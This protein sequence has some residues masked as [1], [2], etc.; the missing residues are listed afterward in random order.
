MSYRLGVDLG[1]TFSAAAIE[2]DGRAEIVALGNN[3]AQIPSVLFLQPDGN[4]RFGEAANRRGAE[5]PTRLAREFKRRIGDRTSIMVGSTPISPQALTAKLLR[6]TFDRVVERQGG[7]PALTVVT[8]PANWGEY[9]REL[10]SNATHEADIGAAELCPEPEA[11]AVHFSSTDRVRTGE[12][13]AVYDLGGGTFD[14]A[15]LRRTAEGFQLLG[16][17]EG[18]E[19]LGG[20]DFDEAVF[21]H[22]LTS[23]DGDIRGLDSDDPD[24]LSALARLRRE[25]VEAKE[26]LSADNEAPIP[27]TLPG[28]QRTVRLTRSEFEDMIRPRLTETVDC[29]ARAL[30]SA[31]LAPTDLAAVVLV[32]GS[33]R[34]P[35]VSEMLTQQFRRPIALSPHPKHCVALGAALRAVPRPSPGAEARAS[36][37]VPAGP[38]PVSAGPIKAVPVSGEPVKAVPVSAVPVSTAPASPAPATTS[39]DAARSRPARSR[40][41]RSSR[42]AASTPWRGWL[43]FGSAAIAVVIALL[44]PTQRSAANPSS[45][46]F[47]SG[48]PLRAAGPVPLDFGKVTVSGSPRLTKPGLLQ[49]S[50]AGAHLQRKATAPSSGTLGFD[51]QND[52]LLV[53][54]PVHGQLKVTSGGDQKQTNLL[55]VPTGRHWW[56]TIPGGALVVAILFLVAYVESLTRGIRHRRSLRG[57][58]TIA[59]LLLGLLAAAALIDAVW[60]IPKRLLTPGSTVAV[61]V[62]LA[63][64]FALVPGALVKRIGREAPA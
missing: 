51:L 4:F 14:A 13:I 20:V 60:I 6:W 64:A 1:T 62:L 54:G 32:G 10:L 46:L 9:R 49:L 17:A 37:I 23:L 34:V 5:Q 35:L 57:T 15:V 7:R 18:I 42:R 59:M 36:E 28:L 45:G 8:H 48:H 52:R 11:A 40:P 61:L 56:T 47:M 38:A 12:V 43:A 30:A 3:V 41:A 19:H 53:A 25:C 22:V 2:R 16:S 27:V 58:D 33:A 26:A 63:V 50:V 55:V 39:P 44:G 24:V 31:E 21:Q 29:L